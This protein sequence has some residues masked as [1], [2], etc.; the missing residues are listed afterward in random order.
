MQ[1]IMATV[2]CRF[3]PEF[4]KRVEVEPRPPDRIQLKTDWNREREKAWLSLKPTI[5]VID[6]VSLVGQLGKN[7]DALHGF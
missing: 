2:T 4:N 3:L 1:L 5:T 6:R 7:C